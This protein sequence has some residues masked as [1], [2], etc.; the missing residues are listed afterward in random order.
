M[1]ICSFL[2]DGKIRTGIL[3]G[4]KVVSLK[5]LNDKIGID[6]PVT[7]DG[8]IKK[9]LVDELR[10]ITHNVVLEDFPGIPVSEIKF[11]A[12]YYNPPKIWG[13]GLNFRD[14]ANDLSA[15]QP[16]KKPASFMKPAT[17]IIGPG[18]K[19]KLPPQSSYVT[20]EAEIG[21]IICRE[22]KN[23]SVEDVPDII[24]GFTTILDM[25]A[26][27]ILKENPRFL[28]RAKSFDT[29]F[30]FGPW[31]VTPEE[32]NELQH[33]KI[34]TLINGKEH[35]RNWVGNMNFQPFELVAFHSQ[36]MTLKPGDIISC[37][38]PGAVK[39]NPGD[40][41]GCK[42]SSIGSLENNVTASDDIK[43]IFNVKKNIIQSNDFQ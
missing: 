23:I 21:I 38:T 36:N 30:S 20:G 2:Q 26:V 13:I 29:F 35:C 4:K 24:L 6:F 40:H 5:T 7:L 42:V 43:K 28:T 27:D 16:L 19:I 8:I 1:R 34:T 14:H 32:I 25:T 10:R 15:E 17:S 41:L 3:Q 33:V 12:P 11:C 22:C 9:N 18:D 37:G 31:I 39:L